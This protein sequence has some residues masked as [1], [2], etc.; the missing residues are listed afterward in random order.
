M[1]ATESACSPLSSLSAKWILS[2]SIVRD[3]GWIGVFTDVLIPYSLRG[4]VEPGHEPGLRSANYS[5]GAGVAT[6][7][8]GIRTGDGAREVRTALRIAIHTSATIGRM[9]CA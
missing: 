1:K 7:D 4:F 8:S 5:A 3:R 6:A 9:N 2:P